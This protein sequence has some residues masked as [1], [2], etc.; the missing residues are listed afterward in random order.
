MLSKNLLLFSIL[1]DMPW[2]N[3]IN[4]EWITFKS[5][6]FNLCKTNKS[7]L[8]YTSSN[9]LWQSNFL[10]FS[11]TTE[12]LEKIFICSCRKRCQLS[13]YML[14]FCCLCFLMKI[15]EFLK[16]GEMPKSSRNWCFLEQRFHHFL[17]PKLEKVF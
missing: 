8:I 15:K 13:F 16:N 5:F 6:V 9:E 12:R 2:N 3:T 7:S 11:V 14:F 10:F 17:E 1:I 4:I